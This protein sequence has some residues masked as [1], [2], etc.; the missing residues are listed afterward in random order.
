[1]L[2]PSLEGL[3]FK[4]LREE[5]R[6]RLEVPFTGEEIRGC[7]EACNGEKAQVP[8]GFNLK[9]YQVFW[10]VIKKEVAAV[11][12]DFHRMSFF[13]Q[14]INTFSLVIILKVVG[15]KNI[16]DFR[17]IS[18]VDNMYKLLSKVLARTMSKVLGKIIGKNLNAFVKGR[19]ILN[20]VMIASDIVDELVGQKKEN[21]ICKIDM[22][23]VYDHVSWDFVNYMMD[24][25]GFRGI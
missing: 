17:S 1:M 16:K 15:T 2:D 4:Q 12:N 5:S 7:L 18:L 8:N 20:S 3:D 13:V 21:I 10:E 23:K 9:F 22:E 24:K 6:M 19:Q 25:L 11:S 14:S